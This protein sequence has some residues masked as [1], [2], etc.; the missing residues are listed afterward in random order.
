MRNCVFICLCP[1][2]WLTEIFSDADTF[3]VQFP[4]CMMTV[5]RKLL[6]IGAAMMIEFRHFEQQPKEGP[7]GI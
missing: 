5:E 1:G 6:L 7:D 4:D 2:G 3:L